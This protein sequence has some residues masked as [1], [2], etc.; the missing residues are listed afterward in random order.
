MSEIEERLWREAEIEAR[1][2]LANLGGGVVQNLNSYLNPQANQQ[3]LYDRTVNVY[4][5]KV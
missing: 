4:N 1:R 5:W 3:A 2:W